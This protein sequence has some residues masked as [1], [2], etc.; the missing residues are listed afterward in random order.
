MSAQHRSSLSPA[1]GSKTDLVEE[2]WCHRCKYSATGSRRAA[3]KYVGSEWIPPSLRDFAEGGR[4]YKVDPPLKP[5]SGANFEKW[6]R[7]WEQEQAWKAAWEKKHAPEGS[8]SSGALRAADEEEE[9][10]EGEDPLFLEAVAASKEDADDKARAEAEE[11]AQAI[12]AVNE[13]MAREATATTPLV[14]LD[15]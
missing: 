7:E 5:M 1:T 3:C 2:A 13:L 8:S 9:A 4:Y 12:A 10:E 15:D 14:I 11:A 6:W